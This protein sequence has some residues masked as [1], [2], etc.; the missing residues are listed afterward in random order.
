MRE[1]ITI[2]IG[3]YHASRTPCVIDTILGSCVAVCLFDPV[4][5]I[6]G[7]N[8]IF[9]PGRADTSRFNEPARYGVNAMELL[10]N[11]MMKLGAVKKQMIAKV[12]GGGHLFGEVK[13]YPPIGKQ[14]AEFAR[15]FLKNE[16]IHI[17][18][19]DLGGAFGRKVFLHSDT[20]DV[21]MKRIPSLRHNMEKAIQK[22]R[23]KIIGKAIEKPGEITIF[24]TAI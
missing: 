2:R 23:M 17:A 1:K 20:G 8:H 24:S 18:S 14:I 5:R 19:R 9:L 22:Q 12:F 6:G 10:I 4:M 16:Q 21:F 13:G 7:M 3:E 11:R 15:C